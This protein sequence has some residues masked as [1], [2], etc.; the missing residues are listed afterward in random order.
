MASSPASAAGAGAIAGC[1]LL[2]RPNLAPLAAVVGAIVLARSDRRMRDLAVFVAATAPAV[3]FIAALNTVWYGSPLQSGY[4]SLD[5]LYSADRVLP[6]LRRYVIWLVDSQTPAVAAAALAPFVLRARRERVLIALITVMF[7]CAV[8]ALYLPYLVF[9]DWSYLRF[10]LPA[11]PPICAGLAA[12]LIALAARTPVALRPIVAGAVALALAV[13][14]LGYSTAF[15][16][17]ASDAR[18]ARVV[19]YAEALPAKSVFVSLTHAGT[20]SQYTGRGTLRWDLFGNGADLD[21]AVSYLRGRGYRVYLVADAVEMD[22][23]TARVRGSR[24]ASAV[25]TTVPA[26]LGGVVIYPLTP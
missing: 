13:H 21:R 23:F 3:V 16:I 17:A 14:G 15:A 25:A 5:Y 7:P 2:I 19:A 1:A 9:D 22:Q 10:L 4:G 26:D 12:V 8:F 6:N 18:Y 24:S 11:F 20:I